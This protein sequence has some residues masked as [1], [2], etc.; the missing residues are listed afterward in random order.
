MR[1]TLFRSVLLYSIQRTDLAF[2]RSISYVSD[3][4]QHHH[5]SHVLIQ[6][7]TD[8]RVKMATEVMCVSLKSTS[9]SHH[10]VRTMPPVWILRL[11]TSVSVNRRTAESFHCEDSQYLVLLYNS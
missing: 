9:V 1:N 7:P 8:A 6:C 11:D 2:Q 10:R 3:I 4:Q 5:G